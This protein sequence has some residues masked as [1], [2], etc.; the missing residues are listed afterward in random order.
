MHIGRRARGLQVRSQGGREGGY[1]EAGKGL[2][3]E[4][5]GGGGEGGGQVLGGGQGAT[6]DPG[7]RGRGWGASSGRWARGLRV[8]RGKDTY[9]EGQE[10]LPNRNT[11][12][13][14][15]ASSAVGPRGGGSGM[16]HSP[17]HL[18]HTFS[19]REALGWGGHHIHTPSH[20]FQA[21]RPW[22]GGGGRRLSRRMTATPVPPHTSFTLPSGGEAL[23]RGA[24]ALEEYDSDTSIKMYLEALDL[25]EEV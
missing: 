2:Q 9:W 7:R 11:S 20:L 1:R 25:F 8:T 15:H 19:G 4:T 6:G 16:C 21:G 22:G 14:S 12:L 24:K 13:T 23:G 10:Q 3:Q 18:N 5:R 17:P